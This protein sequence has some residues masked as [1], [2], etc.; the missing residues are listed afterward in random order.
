MMK[1]KILAVTIPVVGCITVVGAGF[2]AW[3]FDEAVTDSSE[4]SALN[5]YVTEKVDSND[6]ALSFINSNKDT[7]L[8]GKYL[9]LDQGGVKNTDE[10]V[11]IMIADSELNETVAD[12]VEKPRKYNFTVKFGKDSSDGTSP[13]LTLNSIYDAHM[14]LSV[15]VEIDLSDRLY[16]YVTLVDG[17]SAKMKVSY[18]QTSGENSEFFD[19]KDTDGDHIWTATY[20][21]EADKLDDLSTDPI[22]QFEWNFEINLS[23]NAELKNSLFR[24]VDNK[25]P[26][27]SKEYDDMV[28]ALKFDEEGTEKQAKLDFV[29]TAK[30]GAVA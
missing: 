3:Y 21:L 7:V 17:E 30:I 16:Q 20:T 25:K 27:I 14:E 11:G 15:T 8:D 22:S 23:T 28:K 2:S 29:T 6:V 13:K 9:I 1:R 5:T 4:S 10:T 26:T 18:T 24:Y 12:P 19:F